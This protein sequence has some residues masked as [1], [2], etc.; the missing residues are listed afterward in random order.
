MALGWWVLAGGLGVLLRYMMVG[1]ATCFDYTYLLHAHSHVVLLGW[2]CNALY[3]GLVASFLPAQ[4]SSSYRWMWI[5]FQIAVAGMLVFF[6]IQGYAAGSIA[7]STVHVLLTYWMSVRLWRD[8]RGQ[9][10]LSVGLLRWGI[11]FLVLSTIGPYFLGYFKANQ[12]QHTIWYNL[13]IYYY[14]HFLYNGWFQFG[15][16]ALLFRW[17]ENREIVLSVPGS[18]LF[19]RAM[20]VAVFGTLALSALWTSPPAWIWIV[21]ALSAIIQTIAG[22]WLIC[23]V[24]QFRKRIIQQ[25]QPIAALLAGLAIIS[26]ALKIFLQLFSVLPWAVQFSSQ[27]RP[28][29]IAYLHLVFIGFI[30]FFLM[31]W[32]VQYKRL[33]LS[34]R[35]LRWFVFFFTVSEL[36]LVVPALLVTTGFGFMP[37]YYESLLVV[38]VGLWMGVLVIWVKQLRMSTGAGKIHS[39]VSR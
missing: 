3:L 7:F 15:C 5:G 2:A 31:A 9:K 36:L 6:P 22:G 33:V 37:Y 34:R 1:P 30:S 38:S 24:W 21:G 19:L 13:S 11:I 18:T 35:V 20:V 28:I 39:L 25:L 17:F 27:Q 32:A 10:S 4:R 8:L 16:L 23:F 29:V 12:M 26:F 14:L